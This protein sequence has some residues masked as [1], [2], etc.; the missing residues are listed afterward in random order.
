METAPATMLSACSPLAA[1]HIGT[2]TGLLLQAQV[3]AGGA[4]QLLRIASHLACLPARLQCFPSEGPQMLSPALQRLLG[5]CL[6]PQSGEPGMV[7]AAALGVMARVLL[8]NAT[9]FLQ[10]FEAAAAALQPGE[11]GGVPV[12]VQAAS[13]CAVHAVQAAV[14]YT[15]DRLLVSSPAAPFYCL[16]A[17]I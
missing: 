6:L 7:V 15:F 17:L 2:G 4:Q 3:A 10:F 14:S 9:F 16:D 13:V 12:M 8:H 5:C 11:G 1:V